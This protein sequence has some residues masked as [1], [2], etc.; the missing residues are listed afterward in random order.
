[1]KKITFHAMKNTQVKSVHRPIYNY[2]KSEGYNVEWKRSGNI[3]VSCMTVLPNWIFIPHGISLENFASTKKLVKKRTFLK[4]LLFPGSYW[5]EKFYSFPDEVPESMWRG[6]KELFNI[7]K[8]ELPESHIKVVGWP[9]SDLLFSP[10]RKEV[11]AHW[12]NKLKLPHDKTLLYSGHHF[13]RNLIDL[14]EKLELNLICKPTFTYMT[15]PSFQ[16][17]SGKKLEN[18]FTFPQ[19]ME[20]YKG[21]KHVNFVNPLELEDITELFLVSDICISPSHS[22]VAT[23]FLV[24]NKPLIALGRPTQFSEFLIKQEELPS[25]VCS[26]DGIKDAIVHSLDK[27]DEFKRQR[28]TWLKKMVYKPDGKASKRAWEAIMELSNLTE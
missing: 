13:T 5:K 3:V 4:G 24:T 12:I 22:S 15:V 9:K 17:K 23:E 20:A 14:T 27:P 18:R 8:T 2:A 6:K 7:K 1:M 11:K 16:F 10:R 25:I 19:V 26:F 21:F 28:E